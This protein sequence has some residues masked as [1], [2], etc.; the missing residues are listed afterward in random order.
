MF[1]FV[2]DMV[3]RFELPDDECHPLLGR[4][5]FYLG[6]C[7]ELR[8]LALFCSTIMATSTKHVLLFALCPTTRAMSNSRTMEFK[9]S[10]V[11][12]PRSTV[13]GA[14]KLKYA[15][16]SSLS[17]AKALTTRQGE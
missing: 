15:K 3:S 9:T 16:S 5:Y 2:E 1:F 4:L 17:K 8:H 11:R 14:T 6:F 13:C 10:A 7:Q 12:T